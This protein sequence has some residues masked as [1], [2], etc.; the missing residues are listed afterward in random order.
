MSF[1][2]TSL[3][4][5]GNLDSKTKKENGIFFTPSDIVNLVLEKVT[6]YQNPA[7]VEKIL[8][9]SCGSGEFI[10]G[11]D[12]FYSAKEID[13]IEKNKQI[14]EEIES[15]IDCENNNLLLF[16][17]DFVT[18]PPIKKYQLIVGNPPY[19]VVPK[20]SI[21]K[22]F[23]HLVSG[24]PNLFVLFIIQSIQ[25]LTLDGVLAFLLPKSFLNS[26]YYSKVRNYLYSNYE[27]LEICDLESEF[28]E[29]KQATICLIV[30]NN[31]L[32]SDSANSKWCWGTAEGDMVMTLSPNMNI[33]FST[34]A[35]SLRSLV[36]SSTSLKNM[37]LNTRTGTIVWNQYKE[38]LTN[39][40]SDTLLIYNT[41]IQNGEF[42]EVEFKNKSKGQYIKKSKG[43]QSWT[44][45]V[46]VVNRGNGNSQ[47]KFKY[48][49]IDKADY[50]VENHLN[51]IEGPIEKLNQVLSSF[52]DPRTHEFIKLYFGNN[53]MSKTELHEILP[54]YKLT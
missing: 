27:I 11:L 30:R 3:R 5:T 54:I 4:L 10:R 6:N 50:L 23:N 15:N 21:A 1:S 24:R 52:S 39:N 29:T 22:K 16:N 33:I 35:E 34:Q 12:N 18:E 2:Q 45:P 13:A 20:N 26:A 38:Y 32:T 42:K 47:Y 8:E 48:A 40:T 31:K 7:Q 14:F 25:L 19:V 36:E 51:V 37:G 53:G 28:L 46:I 17:R 43:K 9:P 41:N 49:L 44:N